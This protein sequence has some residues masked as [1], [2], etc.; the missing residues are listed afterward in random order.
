MTY[1]TVNVADSPDSPSVLS[2]TCPVYVPAGRLIVQ[3]V[4]D[5]FTQDAPE[6]AVDP[7]MNSV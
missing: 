5:V 7:L 6:V 3:D 1:V 4:L 2:V